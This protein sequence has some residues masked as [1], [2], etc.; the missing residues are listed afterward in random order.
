[1][2]TEYEVSEASAWVSS[3]AVELNEK[4]KEADF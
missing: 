3:R 4:Q 1:M 2:G